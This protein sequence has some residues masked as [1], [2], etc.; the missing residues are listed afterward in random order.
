VLPT[1]SPGGGQIRGLVRPGSPMTNASIVD[2]NLLGMQTY[3][4]LPDFIQDAKNVGIGNKAIEA[5]F[6]SAD[7]YIRMWDKAYVVSG[8]TGSERTRCAAP[9]SRV[10]SRQT[11]CAN[12]C[13][14]DPG[15]GM[16]RRPNGA[17]YQFKP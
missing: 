13:P 15:R 16:E 11:V 9:P 14:D 8:C 6:N 12:T 7:R 4:L 2:Y 5:L 10:L 17:S 1:Q 3:G